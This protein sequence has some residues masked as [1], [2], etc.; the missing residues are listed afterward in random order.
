LGGAVTGNP[1]VHEIG[2]KLR[3]VI[4]EGDQKIHKRRFR[5]CTIINA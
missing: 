5:R 3:R 4:H 2:V 1:V